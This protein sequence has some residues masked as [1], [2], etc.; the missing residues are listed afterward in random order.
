[1]DANESK[2]T[3]ISSQ[4][5][6]QRHMSGGPHRPVGEISNSADGSC[7]FESSAVAVTGSGNRTENLPPALTANA[8][9]VAAMLEISVRQVWRLSNTGRL[10]RPVRL[11]NCV[12]WRR[13]EIE[14]HLA[15]G[16]PTREEWE[17][18]KIRRID[19]C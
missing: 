8:S 7:R 3:E 12:R 16:C 2:K 15:A 19:R 9:Q 1:M 10:P 14:A 11:G 17:R 5:V 4:K 13:A 6:P 18:R